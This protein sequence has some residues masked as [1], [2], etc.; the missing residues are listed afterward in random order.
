MKIINLKKEI[1]NL[2]RIL[3]LN[4]IFSYNEISLNFFFKF[5]L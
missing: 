4:K 2:L 3:I 1:I 5:I